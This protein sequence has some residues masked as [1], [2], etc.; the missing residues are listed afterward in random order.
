MT[1][2]ELGNIGDFL[3]G[4]AVVITLLYLALQI[5]KQSADAKLEATR[6]LAGEFSLA[7]SLI[8]ENKEL[9]QIYLRGIRDYMSLPDEDRLRLSLCFIRLVRA[10][11]QQ[12]LHVRLGNLD[13]TYF[14]SIH[15]SF[16]EFLA[17]P[18]VQEWWR[19]SSDTFEDSFYASTFF[20]DRPRVLAF[21]LDRAP[22]LLPDLVR[23]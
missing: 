17:F 18:G 20:F 6:A 7:I 10:M 9:C 14:I 22:F 5:R 3:G 2:D 1:L 11:E 21:G 23:W 15:K 13:G 8:I 19:L 4:V 16:L 12:Y